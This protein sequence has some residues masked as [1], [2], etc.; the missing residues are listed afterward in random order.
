MSIR[1]F[2]AICVLSFLF[3]ALS[4]SFRPFQYYIYTTQWQYSNVDYSF[5]FA[6]LT[7][8]SITQLN[9]LLLRVQSVLRDGLPL[10][11]LLVINVLILQALVTATRR[12]LRMQRGGTTAVAVLHAQRA[13]RSKVI[14]IA[15]TGAN[16]IILHLPS[17]VVYWVRGDE[18]ITSFWLCFTRLAPW[19]L[20]LSYALNIL[21]YL[22]FNKHF[23]SLFIKWFVCTRRNNQ[24]TTTQQTASVTLKRCATRNGL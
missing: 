9:L 2:Y 18:F 15:V 5:N 17:L 1:W 12:K 24:V 4:N 19:L 11:V 22:G 6:K 13:E 8:F 16:F 3:S 7:N 20:Q 21:V 23:R 10:V 14:M